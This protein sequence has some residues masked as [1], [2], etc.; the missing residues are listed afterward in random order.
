MEVYSEAAD[1]RARSSIFIKLKYGSMRIC[2]R[3]IYGYGHLLERL[4]LTSVDITTCGKSEWLSSKFRASLLVLQNGN[5]QTFGTFLE[6]MHSGPLSK[7][8]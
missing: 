8:R 1:L 4:M 6:T 3:D 2:C 7:G 5:Y